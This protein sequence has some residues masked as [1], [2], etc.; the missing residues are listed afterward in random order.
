[1]NDEGHIAIT[2]LE[3]KALLS[4]LITE[5]WGADLLV[6]GGLRYSSG[7]LNAYCARDL[8]GKLLGFVTWILRGGTICVLSLDSFE[9]GAGIGA[10]LLDA[11]FAHGRQVNAK[12]VRALTT[13]DNARALIYYQ[14]RGF[15]LAALYAGAIDAYRAMNP[16]LRPVG[17]NGIAVRDAIELEMSL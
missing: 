7:N 4:Q 10:R 6:M 12:T 13:N 17:L 16:K 9:A 15:H 5:R 11:I 3:D 8:G 2:A 14:R 1:M